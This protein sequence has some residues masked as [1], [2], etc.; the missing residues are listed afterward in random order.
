METG[1]LDIACSLAGVRV[2]M[3]LFSQ[4]GHC[5]AAIRLL[6]DTIPPLESLGLPPAIPP[7][8]QLRRGLV[9]VTGETG[10]GKTTTPA[11]LLT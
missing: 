10:S 8:A 11:A 5:A 3:H 7:L 9:F 1:S 4:Q 6:R 2:R